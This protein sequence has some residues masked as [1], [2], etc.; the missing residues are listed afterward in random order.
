MAFVRLSFRDVEDRD[1]NLKVRVEDLV[2]Q[3]YFQGDKNAREYYIHLTN[4]SIN[5]SSQYYLKVGRYSFRLDGKEHGID[6]IQKIVFL[7]RDLENVAR[8]PNTKVQLPVNASF[9]LE[10]LFAIFTD[11]LLAHYMQKIQSAHLESHIQPPEVLLV[12]GAPS[13]QEI[14]SILNA[15]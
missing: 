7:Q 8:K 9:G 1:R 10:E 4:G 2:G 6:T 14:L 13:D 3:Y 15:T 5:V 12:D 11:A